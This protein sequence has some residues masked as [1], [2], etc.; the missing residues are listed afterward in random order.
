ME[1]VLWTNSMEE[2]KELTKNEIIVFAIIIG[3]LLI[4]AIMP[5]V[6]AATSTVITTSKGSS[7]VASAS[8]GQAE[9]NTHRENCLVGERAANTDLDCKVCFVVNDLWNAHK[10]KL[11]D[12][13]AEFYG[14]ADGNDIADFCGEFIG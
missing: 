6:H 5:H 2:K 13:L 1:Y 14:F 11:L 12:E 8:A 9:F 4:F 7:A 10:V 3:I